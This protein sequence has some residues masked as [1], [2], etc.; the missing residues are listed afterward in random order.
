[1]KSEKKEGKEIKHKIVKKKKI[2]QSIHKKE[3]GK[4][5]EE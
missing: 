4:Q 1:M 3:N 2:T 5:T